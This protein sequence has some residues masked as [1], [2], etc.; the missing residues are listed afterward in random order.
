M[1][2]IGG[3]NLTQTN[4]S[5]YYNGSEI[6]VAGQITDNDIETFSPQVVAI[7]VRINQHCTSAVIFQKVCESP[8]VHSHNNSFGL[9]QNNRRVVFSDPNATVESTGTVSD[10]HI[11]R[12]W[13]YLTVKQLL[14]KEWVGILD[15]FSLFMFVGTLIFLFNQ[16]LI[17]SIKCN[18][19]NTGKGSLQLYRAQGDI[20]YLLACLTNSAKQ[21][22]C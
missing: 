1:V 13:A 11:Q 4:F 12:V 15:L 10:S 21:K 17:E 7:S 9:W 3:T 18:E 14:E 16:S 5:Q 19:K 20:F 22:R 8:Y 6:V 2:Y